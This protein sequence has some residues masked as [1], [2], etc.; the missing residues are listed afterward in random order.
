[1][2]GFEVL[3]SGLR[4]AEQQLVTQLNGVRDAISALQLGTGQRGRTA[5]SL[6]GPLTNTPVKRRG[7]RKISEATRAKM[8]AAAQ[9]RWASQR[10]AEGGSKR[11][12]LTPN[13]TQTNGRTAT[14]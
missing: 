4:R 6:P 14:K 9:K 10:R 3:L 8:R 5:K 11:G 7:R 12:S 13:R 2:A 1:M